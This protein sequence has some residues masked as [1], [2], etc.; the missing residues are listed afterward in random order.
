MEVIT[1]K[2]VKLFA[3]SRSLATFVSELFDNA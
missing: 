1:K 2:V 3:Q